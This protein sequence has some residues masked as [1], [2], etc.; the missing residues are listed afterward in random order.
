MS[1]QSLTVRAAG[2]SD[3]RSLRELAAPGR[4]PAPEGHVLL[5]ERDRAAVAAISI[6]SGAILTDPFHAAADAVRSLRMS[7]YRVLRQSQ[8]TGRARSALRRLAT[9]AAE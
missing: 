2:P 6:T 1:D 9:V 3:A 7:R 4:R 5:A 8:G